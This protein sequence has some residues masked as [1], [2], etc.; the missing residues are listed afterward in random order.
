MHFV[1]PLLRSWTCWSTMSSVQVRHVLHVLADIC[2]FLSPSRRG[3]A[4]FFL[5][6]NGSCDT[7]TPSSLNPNAVTKFY[8]TSKCW[9]MSM[10][11]ARYRNGLS[12]SGKPGPNL[13]MPC[14]WHIK[15]D[16][17]YLKCNSKAC[18]CRLHRNEKF[19]WI[20]KMDSMTFE[21]F[22][23]DGKKRKIR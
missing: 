8:C 21:F 19:L 6:H 7:Q 4:V 18:S 10:R 23:P 15:V 9:W 22:R 3:V 13:F 2:S 16:K 1:D 12:D 11:C 17:H 20:K 5:L 14:A